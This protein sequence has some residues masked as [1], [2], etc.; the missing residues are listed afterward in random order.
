MEPGTPPNTETLHLAGLAAANGPWL[1]ARLRRLAEISG[2]ALP[3][4]VVDSAVEQCSLTLRRIV[5]A[6]GRPAFAVDMDAD[7]ATELGRQQA[8]VHMEAGLD[9][10]GSLRVLRLM[11][12]A[13]DDLIRESWI[14]DK[15]S[16]ARAHEDVERVFERTLLG[17]YVAWADAPC[18]QPPAPAAPPEG[19]QA[20]EERQRLAGRLARRESELRRTLEAAHK[21]ADLL[22]Q[23]RARTRL[24]EGELAARER[25]TAPL[26]LAALLELSGEAL[27]VVDA[28][29]RFEAWSPRFPA[30]FGLEGA[31]L[32]QGLDALLPRMAEAL[33][34][35][36]PFLARLRGLLAS[37]EPEAEA[38]QP[39]VLATRSGKTLALRT[40]TAPGAE[41]RPRLRLLA[42]RDVTPE[43]DAR[44]LLAELEAATRLEPDS[45]N[46]DFL[47]LSREL[48][49]GGAL[50]PELAGRV[51]KACCRGWDVVGAVRQ[52]V[53][54]YTLEHGL[55]RP[56]PGATLDLAEA[57]RQAVRLAAPLAASR[58]VALVL[59][60]DNPSLPPGAPLPE[61]LSLTAPGD[62]RLARDLACHLLR[63]AL[64]ATAPGGEVDLALAE[65]ST[66]LTLSVTRP[67]ELPKKSRECF[68][69]K[70]APG[71][72][73]LSAAAA[74]G[75]PG[76]RYAARLLAAALGGELSAASAQGRGTSVV[77]RLPKS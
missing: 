67:R 37:Q 61:G 53:D 77:L 46:A 62:Q 7:P 65:D 2:L 31:D 64:A 6:E 14:D 71:G 21:A 28:A 15:G 10:P 23:E 42:L 8:G 58:Q 1:A 75:N 66:G 40:R 24:L 39:L 16:R 26:A 3:Q 5:K 12:R 63:D 54:V 72:E 47:Q 43:R 17:L 49:A 41:G 55:Y 45:P 56:E 35:P 11:R 13:Y 44:T 4:P 60:L 51:A 27:A 76:A 74:P 20:L 50:P 29:G 32:A 59:T 9:L 33:H 18:A 22:R 25:G 69:D 38:G 52:A 57:V 73:C 19:A 30:L 34:E 36:E 70:P 48:L 68:F